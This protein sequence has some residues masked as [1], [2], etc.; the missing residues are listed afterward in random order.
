MAFVQAAGQE[1]QGRTLRLA[2]LVILAVALSLGVWRASSL[3]TEPDTTP[4]SPAEASIAAL[5]EPIAGPRR[6]RV[7]V[8]RNPEGGRTVFVLLDAAAA[9]AAPELQRILPAA[10]GL[11]LDRADRLIIEETVFAR[12]LPGRPDSAAWMELG[13]LGL[14]SFIAAGIALVSLRTEAA[15]LPPREAAAPVPADLRPEPARP[16]RAVPVAMAPPDASDVAR[17][18]PARAAAVLRRWMADREDAS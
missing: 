14:I 12:G 16:L 18:D 5:V 11:Q 17:R 15:Q 10:A 4:N 9:P 7:S 8:M 2:T 3:L 13:G 1:T 6:A